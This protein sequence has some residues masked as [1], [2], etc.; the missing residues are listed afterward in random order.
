LEFVFDEPTIEDGK[1]ICNLVKDSPPLDVNSEYL[2]LLLCQHFS[3]TCVVAKNESK[4][5]GFVSAYIPPNQQDTLFIWQ[6]AV[7]K[8]FRKK[9]IS[10]KMIQSIL[11]RPVCGSVSYLEATVT[12]SNL[13]SKNMFES[14][15]SKLKCS[16]S[17]NPFFNLDH[18]NQGHEPENLVRIGPFEIER[19]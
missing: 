18:F 17:T 10:S 6:V 2:Y 7:A 5:I 4:I 12:P 15:A 16:I 19:G 1:E 14:F 8:E 9:G 3:K 13:A 11:S